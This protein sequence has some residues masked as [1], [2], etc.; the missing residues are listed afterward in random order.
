MNISFEGINESVV[1]FLTEEKIEP[2]SLV[3]VVKDNTVKLASEDENFIGVCVSCQGS[4][5]AIKIS[6]F[7]EI[8]IKN[9][10]SLKYGL[11]YFVSD[12]NGLLKLSEV[13]NP[14]AVP[15]YVISIDKTNAILGVLMK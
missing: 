6:G 9:T 1:T 13:T 4:V 14:S 2:G 11:Q 12:V 10:D 7:E 3:T 8:K 5:A 15:L